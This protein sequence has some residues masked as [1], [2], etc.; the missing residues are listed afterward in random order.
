MIDEVRRSHGRIDVL[1]HAGG[2]EISKPLP[3]KEPKEFD[4]V[5]DVKADGFFN[6]LQAAEGLP[7]G[8]TVAF[9][10]V[11]GR[12]GN[13]GQ[14]DYSAANDLLCKITSSMRRWR[15]ETRARVPPFCYDNRTAR[16]ARSLPEGG[17]SRRG[18]GAPER[19][20]AVRRRSRGS[21]E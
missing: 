7:I 4:L 10:S 6:L 12:F 17:A 15:P 13:S 20:R 14:T 3:D 21:A 9:S 2:L 16:G 18:S 5:F 19:D 8:A 11:A 1:L